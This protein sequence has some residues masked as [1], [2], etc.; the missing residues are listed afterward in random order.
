MFAST[1]DSTGAH[2]SKSLFNCVET[3]VF[4]VQESA[5]ITVENFEA[6][7]HCVRT[8]AEASANG[9]YRKCK[10]NSAASGR[11]GSSRSK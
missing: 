7:V 8:F 11:K 4:L 9:G 5:Q 2:D 10:K 3:L 1:V 6:C